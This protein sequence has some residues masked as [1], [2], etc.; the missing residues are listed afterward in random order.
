MPN[1]NPR[2]KKVVD[3]HMRPNSDRM[4]GLITEAIGLAKMSEAQG[5]SDL[6]PANTEAI[7]GSDS[8]GRSPVTNADA[9]ATLQAMREFIEWSQTPSKVTGKTPFAAF[10][11][12]AVNPR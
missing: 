10:A 5:T 7:E 1:T 6:F 4:V 8:D 11:K 2:A 9:L 12:L 3:E